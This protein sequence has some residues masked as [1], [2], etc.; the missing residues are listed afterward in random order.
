MERFGVLLIG[1]GHIGMEHLL[2]MYHREDVRVVAV[3]DRN[4][5]TARQA[6]V[7]CGSLWGTD[8]LPFLER[9]DVQ[10]V[11]IATNA[12]SH[13]KILQDCLAHGKHVLCEKPIA[14]DLQEGAQFLEA[15][16]NSSQK[17]LIAHILRHNVSY[18]KIRELVQSGAIG[19]LRLIRM[20]QNHHTTQDWDRHCRLLA[21]CSPA[22]DCGVHYFDLVQWISG[23][24]I[25]E[26]SGFAARTQEDAPRENYNMVHFRTA[27]GC[28][29]FY[30]V[31]WGQ[32]VRSDNLK[33]FIGTKG[34]I[35]LQMQ[36]NRPEDREEG[37]CITV[38][39]SEDNSYTTLNMPAVY[40]NMYGQLECLIH[41]IREDIPANPTMEDVWQAFLVAN[42]AMEAIKEGRTL[43][44]PNPEQ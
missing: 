39:R 10:I 24:P 26:V 38:Y 15:V 22:V 36:T 28:E 1:C 13:L 34:R 40:K 7:R 25:T 31:G 23:S 37:D 20:N 9:S 27:D 2:D 30:E 32:N 4:A 18:R 44:I 16:K 12:A 35:T 8:Y 3:A 43:P 42:T 14:R 29:G 19:Q 17:V 6:A 5:E 21:D 11:I 33:E 41:M